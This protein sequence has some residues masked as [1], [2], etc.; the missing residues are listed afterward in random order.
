[1]TLNRGFL[2]TQLAERVSKFSS[3]F[4]GPP[5]PRDECRPY[6]AQCNSCSSVVCN[7]EDGDVSM[8]QIE[9]VSSMPKYTYVRTTRV[10]KSIKCLLYAPIETRKVVCQENEPACDRILGFRDNVIETRYGIE[11]AEYRHDKGII[12][13]ESPYSHCSCCSEPNSDRGIE[14]SLFL[15]LITTRMTHRVPRNRCSMRTFV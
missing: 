11:E 1:M 9:A 15:A 3:C 10:I 12:G 6:D 4:R 2:I 8:T 13:G 5:E 14:L 7:F